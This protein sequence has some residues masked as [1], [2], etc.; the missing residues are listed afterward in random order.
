MVVTAGSQEGQLLEAS[1]CYFEL[2]AGFPLRPLPRPAQPS[3]SRSSP[4]PPAPAVPVQFTS[5]APRPHR[6]FQGHRQI[7]SFSHLCLSLIFLAGL[8]GKCEP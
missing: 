4:Q 1:S 2:S 8:H 3:S 5:G 7:A 6:T